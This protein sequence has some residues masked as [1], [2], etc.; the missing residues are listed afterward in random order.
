MKKRLY[1]NRIYLYNRDIP[2]VI[3]FSFNLYENAVKDVNDYIKSLMVFLDGP[4]GFAEG[5]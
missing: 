4:E 2:G 5:T 1:I 3:R